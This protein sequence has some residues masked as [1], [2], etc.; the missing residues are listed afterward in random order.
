MYKPA[1]RKYV[2]QVIRH[3]FD[4]VVAAE[5][6]RGQSRTKAV[7]TARALSRKLLKPDICAEMGR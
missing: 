4:S 3:W 1:D 6:A 5:M 7:A 2:L